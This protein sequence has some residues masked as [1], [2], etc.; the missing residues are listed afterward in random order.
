MDKQEEFK[1]WEAVIDKAIQG[2]WKS[3]PFEI[4]YSGYLIPTGF[5]FSKDFAKAF[6]GEECVDY[7]D[8]LTEADYKQKVKEISDEFKN[9]K[10]R[11]WGLDG[12]QIRWKYHLQQLVLQDNYIDYLYSFIKE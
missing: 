12:T 11:E 7:L 1:K 5:I 9:I 10:I 3:A 6:W 4:E 8:G 2:G